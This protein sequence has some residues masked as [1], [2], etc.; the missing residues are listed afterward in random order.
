MYLKKYKNKYKMLSIWSKFC[1]NQETTTHSY[2]WEINYHMSYLSKIKDTKEYLKRHTTNYRIVLQ[3][4]F[5]A[6]NQKGTEATK[7]I[8]HFEYDQNNEVW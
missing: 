2:V 5:P 7:H 4:Y 8:Y 6:R 1:L 3:A